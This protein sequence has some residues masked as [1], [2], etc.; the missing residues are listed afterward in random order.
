MKRPVVRVDASCAL[1]ASLYIPMRTRCERVPTASTATRMDK[2][3]K[4][5]EFGSCPDM[6]RSLSSE[7][8]SELL[9]ND[10]KMDQMIAL[11][12]KVIP[13]AGLLNA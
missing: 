9:Q 11:D 5:T 10:N 2:M 4:A 13:G 1:F 6:Y 3:S 7:E 12:E 8:L